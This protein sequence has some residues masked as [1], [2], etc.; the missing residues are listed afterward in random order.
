V[1]ERN[2]DVRALQAREQSGEVQRIVAGGRARERSAHAATDAAREFD[3]AESGGAALGEHDQRLQ[4]VVEMA[5]RNRQRHGIRADHAATLEVG[6]ARLVQAYARE[7]HERR[8]CRR[9]RSG[10]E[11]RTYERT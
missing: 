11:Q 4:R 7:R 1:R 2:H 5:C 10:T 8:L 9:D 6:D 3:A